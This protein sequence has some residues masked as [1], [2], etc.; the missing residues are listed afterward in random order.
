MPMEDIYRLILGKTISFTLKTL[1]KKIPLKL[2]ILTK[3]NKI[4]LTI[5]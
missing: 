5:I 4:T 1:L 3:I 2:K